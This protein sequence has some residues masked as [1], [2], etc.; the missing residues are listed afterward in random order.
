MGNCEFF[1]TEEAGILFLEKSHDIY[2]NLFSL[3][4][5]IVVLVFLYIALV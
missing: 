5:L 2:F 3:I 4:I 1:V